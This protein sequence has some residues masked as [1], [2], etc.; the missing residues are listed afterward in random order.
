MQQTVKD[1]NE[2]QSLHIRMSVIHVTKPR[3]ATG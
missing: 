3:L 1:E 2:R